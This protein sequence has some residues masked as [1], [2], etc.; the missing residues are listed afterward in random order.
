MNDPFFV[1]PNNLIG[2][3]SLAERVLSERYQCPVAFD[4]IK[5]FQAEIYYTFLKP[6]NIHTEDADA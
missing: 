2:R 3:P 4:P 5:Y 1:V 6:S